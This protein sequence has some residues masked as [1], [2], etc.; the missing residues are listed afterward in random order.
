MRKHQLIHRCP[1]TEHPVRYNPDQKQRDERF[2]EYDPGEVR[3]QK[4]DE[5]GCSDI[6]YCYIKNPVGMWAFFQV[7]KY[8]FVMTKIYTKYF[9]IIRLMYLIRIIYIERLSRDYKLQLQPGFGFFMKSGVF[10]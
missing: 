8:I 10:V 3:Y 9:H 7:T 4:R 1:N 6:Y 2:P 5:D